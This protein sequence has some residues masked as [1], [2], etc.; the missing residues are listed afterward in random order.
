VWN[1]CIDRWMF[2]TETDWCREY[3]VAGYY[4]R[5]APVESEE[6]VSR[7]RGSVPVK[8]VAPDRASSPASHLVSPD[9]LALVRFGLRTA[10]DGRILDTVKVIDA[11]LKMETP[12]GP[13]WHRY[14]GDGYGEH[15]DGEPFD[16][17]G[18]GR[19]WPL[20]TGER[21]HFE[22]A[23]GRAEEA[24][25]LQAAMESFAGAQGLLPEQIWDA[26][27]LPERELYFGRPSGSAMPLVWAHAE[28]LKLLR[29]LRDGRVFD[30]PPQTVERY[31]KNRT[32]PVCMV[33][34]TNHKIRSL[35]TGKTLRVETL[36]PSVVH[37]S[38]DDWNTA[39][40]T[41]TRDTGLGIHSADLATGSLPPGGRVEFTVHPSGAERR[42]EVMFT[43]DIDP[44]R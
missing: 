1:A 18:I 5:I 24:R 7:F 6:S 2:V 8:N 38:A 10:T 12:R 43:V 23:A 17:T 36:E 26:P 27:D 14:N 30:M 37:W 13:A 11:L 34:R 15:E 44:V 22:L 31:L 39:H 3:G 20:L 21:A 9:A 16:G 28:Y 32:E 35:P 40:D 4:I 29:S 19:L 41:A 25:R 42:E 33:W